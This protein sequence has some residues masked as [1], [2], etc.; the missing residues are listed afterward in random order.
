MKDGAATAIFGNRAANGVLM[1]STKRGHNG[2]LMVNFSAQFGF[3]QAMRLPEFLGS[4]DYARL[5]NE[6]LANDGQPA[7]YTAADLEAYRTGSDPLF[8][9]D[10][11]W[12]DQ[13]LRIMLL[14]QIMI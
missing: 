9:P 3:Q 7:L 4:Y 10:V 1:V 13:V 6:G 11:D 12:H 5:Y 14:L 2:P 8:Y